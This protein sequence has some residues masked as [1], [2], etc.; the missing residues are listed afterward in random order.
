M[1]TK[2]SESGAT[3]YVLHTVGGDIHNPEGRRCSRGFATRG[4]AV[5]EETR[6]QER[7][8]TTLVVCIPKD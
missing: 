7:G 2:K 1:M 5:Q 4:E 6:L 3:W 8:R